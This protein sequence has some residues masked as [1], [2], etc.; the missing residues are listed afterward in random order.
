VKLIAG[1]GNPGPRYVDSRHNIGFRVVDELG[2]RW[3]ADVTRYDRAFEGLLGQAAVAGQPVLLLKPATY[4]NLSGRS[5]AAVW[6]FYKL[7]AGDALLIH[8]DLDLPVGQLRIRAAGSAGGHKGMEDVIRHFGTDEFPR[9]RVGIG[10][11]DRDATVEYVLSRFDPPEQPVIEA[12]LE[13][14]ADAVECWLRDGIA[15]AMNRF[16]RR[17]DEESRGPTPPAGSPSEG[18]SPC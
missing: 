18:E 10:R 2:R 6:R 9:V 1:L 5:V 12:A 8:D 3:A 17:K 15:S 7:A 14:A 16:N 11:V 4:M 13:R